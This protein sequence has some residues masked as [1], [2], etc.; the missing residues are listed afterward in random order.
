[1]SFGKPLCEY[2][3]RQWHTRPRESLRLLWV[4]SR[5]DPKFCVCS[6][7]LPDN[8]VLNIKSP[9]NYKYRTVYMSIPHTQMESLTVTS[10]STTH[11]E[12]ENKA[13]KQPTRQARRS[14]FLKD[15]I[16]DIELSRLVVWQQR[17]VVGVPVSHDA[18]SPEG[19]RL[20]LQCLWCKPSS[21]ARK[22]GNLFKL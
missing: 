1:M 7:P 11:C 10:V 15:L 5:G 12:P 2:H 6:L 20:F 9:T 8:W 4:L 16:K 14:Y 22:D 21:W 17:R 13:G 19:F 18:P 3:R